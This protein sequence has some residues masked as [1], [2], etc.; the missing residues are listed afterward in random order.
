MLE[1]AA[2]HLALVLE[3]AG[4]MRDLKARRLALEDRAQVT[5]ASQ[6]AQAAFGEAT[7]RDLRREVAR[8][9]AAETSGRAQALLHRLD[10]LPAYTELARRPLRQG[11]VSL[12]TLTLE[13]RGEMEGEG[14]A[15]W[16]LGELP[17]VRGNRELLRPVLHEL[18]HNA[19]KFSRDR[20]SPT[21]RRVE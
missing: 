17:A 5:H 7:L 8:M 1:T 3:R 9:E 10:D 15:Q 2:Y 12:M 13:V 19:V 16:H 6:Q 4:Q 21:D 18:L 14:H 20:G 11:L